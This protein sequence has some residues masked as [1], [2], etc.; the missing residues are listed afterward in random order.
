LFTQI[1]TKEVHALC[2]ADMQEP[3]V[4]VTGAVSSPRARSRRGRYFIAK[5]ATE[6]NEW[7]MLKY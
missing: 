3:F 4:A 2:G 6:P 1:A 7:E 5:S